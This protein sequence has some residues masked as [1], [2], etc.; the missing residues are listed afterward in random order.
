MALT[1]FEPA[2]AAFHPRLP[3]SLP[4]PPGRSQA[5]LEDITLVLKQAKHRRLARVG[6]RMWEQLATAILAGGCYHHADQVPLDAGAGPATPP[7]A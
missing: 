5:S 2:P 7:A 6:Q 4:D 1:L 3:P